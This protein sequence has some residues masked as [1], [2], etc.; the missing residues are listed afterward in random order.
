VLY[1]HG[2]GFVACTPASYRPVTAWL[3]RR[4]RRRVFAVD[5][6][7]APEHPFPAAPDDVLAAYEWLHATGAAAG[8]VAVA[9]DSAGGNLALGLAVRLR[10]A[11]RPAPACVVAISAWADLAAPR[12]DVDHD[13]L[14]RRGN[15]A[16]FA[17]AY[18]AGA[19]ADDPRASPL[20]AP[21]GGLPPLLQHVGSTEILLEDARRVHE[22]V[23]AAGGES[24]L[25]VYEG[26]PHGWQLM[27]PLVP[28]ATASLRDAADFV[29]A[30]LAPPRPAVH[31]V[32]HA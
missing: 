30:H 1:A 15:F 17:E 29:A 4:T 23:R 11:G 14:F 7:L 27:A 10:D 9:G 13:A 16:Q 2:G 6:R 18:L 20:R 12:P 3:A 25:A 32:A 26:A 19:P 21:L 5:Y 24:R 28:E 31:D 22:G 8:G